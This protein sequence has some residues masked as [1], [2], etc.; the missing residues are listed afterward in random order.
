MHTAYYTC[1]VTSCTSHPANR[2]P[3]LRF[4]Y[5]QL[6][7]S[8]LRT[9][10]FLPHFRNFYNTSLHL[11][12]PESLVAYFS[13]TFSFSIPEKHEPKATRLLPSFSPPHEI[14]ENAII[15]I[16][17]MG[18]FWEKKFTGI[19]FSFQKYKLF[20]FH[21]FNF[22]YLSFLVFFFFFFFTCLCF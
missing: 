10:I 4:I 5:T 22:R 14:R 9:Y 7:S 8:L 2:H 21:L 6:L 3:N 15:S 18:R 11:M 1:M 20:S 17:R 19:Y 12:L 16:S 13:H